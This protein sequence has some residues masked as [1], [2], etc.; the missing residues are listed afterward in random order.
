MKRLV[1]VAA[2]AAFSLCATVA[3]IDENKEVDVTQ[4]VEAVQSHVDTSQIPTGKWLDDNWDAEWHIEQ[5]GIF[6]IYDRD[7]NLL[8]D[9]NGKTE[10]LKVSGSLSKGVTVSFKCA[11]TNK[12]YSFRKGLS[13]NTDLELTVDNHNTGAHYVTTI[14]F[15]K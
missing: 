14:T 7:G 4:G 2:V 8:F 10:G 12:D 5:G 1:A 11:E 3:Q 15:I 13:L 9:F 6:R